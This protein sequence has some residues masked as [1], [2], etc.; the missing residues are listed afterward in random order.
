MTSTTAFFIIMNTNNISRTWVELNQTALINNVKN[1]KKLALHNELGLV[2]KSNAYGHGIV[3]V[4][5][6]LETLPEVD[7]LFTVGFKEACMLR[8]HGITKK[9]LALGYHDLE[10]S[11][12]I[13]NHVHIPLIHSD[14]ALADE[15]N[16]QAQ[17]LMQKAFIHLKIETGLGRLGFTEQEVVSFAQYIKERCPH[18]E[19]YGIY[20][21]LSDPN[22][23][24]LT[25]TYH[26]LDTFNR[27]INNLKEHNIHIPCPHALASGGLSI[28]FPDKPEY[29]YALVRAGGN[30]YGFWKSDL[31]KQRFHA[32]DPSIELEL[33]LT[34]KTKILHIAHHPP[35]NYIGYSRTYTT[36]RD[37]LIAVLP[38]GYD[39]GYPR[40]LS[41]HAHALVNGVLAPVAGL[42][43]MNL[44]AIDVTEVPNVTMGME[45]AL[46]G[47]HEGITPDELAYKAGTIN[48]ELVTGI[49][50]LIERRMIPQPSVC[51]HDYDKP[52]IARI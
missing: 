1:L 31:Q 32:I 9:I 49:N 11:E 36:K 50:P 34:W 13:R 47:P 17:A 25:Y 39:D 29:N 7:W 43:S 45:V 16:R 38:I 21:H 18:I 46:M 22:R 30:M 52:S 41:S 23:E 19:L 51:V 3:A 28:P 10:L 8:S 42:V 40:A 4:S 12:A 27:V 2:V 26:Q 14:R 20:T 5:Q 15:I 48:N 44:M 35:H 6:V 37:S 33:V 24:D